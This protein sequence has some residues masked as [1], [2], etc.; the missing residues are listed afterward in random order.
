MKNYILLVGLS[1]CL[2]PLFADDSSKVDVAHW[3]FE[4][5]KHGEK[6]TMVISDHAGSYDLTLVNGATVVD[7]TTAPNGKAL[8]FDGTQ[9]DSVHSQLKLGLTDKICLKMSAKI[10]STATTSDET[11]FYYFGGMEI[12]YSPKSKLLS[13][14]VYPKTADTSVVSTPIEITQPVD[15]D[16]WFTVEACVNGQ[17]IAY[18]ID[19]NA[20]SGT[21]P[22]N[23]C[24]R[25]TEAPISFG[26]GGPNNRAFI[27]SLSDVSIAQIQ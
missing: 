4:L 2:T 14:I 3:N 20:K 19:G 6:G 16:K 12:R 10:S 17:A 27:G 9:T 22:D 1:L 13:L 25:V 11:L 24:L 21:I 26:I 7:D 15:T 5:V 23:Q 18:K 8:V